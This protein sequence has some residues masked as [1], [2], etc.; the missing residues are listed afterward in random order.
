[1]KKAFTITSITEIAPWRAFLL[2]VFGEISRKGQCK[3]PARTLAEVEHRHSSNP[4]ACKV[5]M[6][7]DTAKLRETKTAGE[8]PELAVSAVVV[9]D[10]VMDG[11]GLRWLDLWLGWIRKGEHA[12][13]MHAALAKID[14]VA[15]SMTC[16]GTQIKGRLGFE[17]WARQF[18]FQPVAVI[19]Q[20]PLGMVGRRK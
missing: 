6:A 13:P 1:M 8:L 16:A 7:L 10:V 19:C 9:T 18:G 14:D 17:R 5:W 4:L 15:A 3:D 12:A 20:K 11:D 2:E